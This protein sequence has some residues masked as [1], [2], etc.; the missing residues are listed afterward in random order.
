MDICI[1]HKDQTTGQKYRNNDV[2]NCN[3]T[4]VTYWTKHSLK[5]HF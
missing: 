5:D 2:S 3:V 4:L 1:L